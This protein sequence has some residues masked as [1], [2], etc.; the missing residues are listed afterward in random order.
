[1]HLNT[2]LPSHKLA[3]EPEEGYACLTVDS[4]LKISFTNTKMIIFFF[5]EENLKKRHF[6]VTNF[7][8]CKGKWYE[9]TLCV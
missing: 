1:M 9:Q 6:R 4:D 5:N 8:G 3:S 7:D 2:Y